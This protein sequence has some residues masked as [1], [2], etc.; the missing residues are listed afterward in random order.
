MRIYNFQRFN[1]TK[2]TDDEE[3]QLLLSNKKEL[4]YLI[5][6]IEKDLA[7]IT[8]IKDFEDIDLQYHYNHYRVLIDMIVLVK[9]IH[10]SYTNIIQNIETNINEY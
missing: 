2:D 6:E 1:E 9:K 7:E 4:E 10:S 5:N 8:A 3:L